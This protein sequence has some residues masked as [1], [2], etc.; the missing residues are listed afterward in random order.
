MNT[1]AGQMSA[2]LH[3]LPPPPSPAGEQDA[4]APYQHIEQD[5]KSLKEVVEM[6]N[7]Q[8]HQQELKISDLEKVVGSNTPSPP[9]PLPRSPPPVCTL[10]PAPQSVCSVNESFAPVSL[11]TFEQAQKNVFL[12][13]KVQVLQ[14]QNEDLKARIEMNL[15][16]SR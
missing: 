3:L 10:A 2:D 1:A 14:Q 4:L 15:T 16:L 13:E 6:K 5:L 8:I 11:S 12:E 7:Q 9:P